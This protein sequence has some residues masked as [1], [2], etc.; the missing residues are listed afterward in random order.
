MPTTRFSSG[1]VVRGFVPRI[2]C[3]VATL[4]LTGG[5]AAAEEIRFNQVELR[6]EASRE[7]PNDLMSARLAVEAH[8]SSP[9]EVAAAL[10]RAT[11]E[12]IISAA[13]FDRVKAQTGQTY[14][15]PVYDRNQRLVGWRGRADVRVESRDFQS[16]AQLAAKVQPN[17]Q[18]G[19]IAFTVSPETR[20]KAESELIAEAVEAFRARA[21]IAQR[22]LGGKAYRIR[23][24]ALDTGATPP[25]RPFAAA[26]AAPAGLA[27]EAPA[28]VFEGGE[29][30]VQVTASG[31]IEV[32]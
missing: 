31:L 9:A 12:A 27:A 15:Y 30:R 28:P 5:A 2:L 20:R 32:E 19:S 13:A 14:T 24:V 25:P 17:M 26:R 8:D 18:L 1:L 3:L 22:A 21:V 23:R 16:L 6:A 11:A 10:N 29:T 7:V 4:T